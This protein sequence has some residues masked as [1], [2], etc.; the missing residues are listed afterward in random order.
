MQAHSYIPVFAI[1]TAFLLPVISTDALSADPKQPGRHSASTI[2]SKTTYRAFLINNVFAYFANNGDG[3]YNPFSG[4]HEG[5]EFYKGQ[6]KHIFYEEGL[7]WGGYHG[8]RVIPKVGGS[9]YRHAL[10]PG[11]IVTGGTAGTTPIAA[12]DTTGD[13]YRIYRVRPDIG[14]GVSYASVQATL[15]NEE[16]SFLS[17]YQTLTSEEVFNQYI[18]DRNEWPA[19]LGAPFTY[20]KN[21]QGIQRTSGPYDPNFDTP[22]I[23]G[24]MQTLWYVANDL[25]SSRTY[26]LAGCPPIGLE[27][28]RTIWGY[29]RNTGALTSSIF[30]RTV[31]VNKSGS[32]VDSMYFAEFSDPD[33]GNAGDDFVGCDTT[34][35][36]GYVYNSWSPDPTFGTN[37]P[38]GGIVLLQGPCVPSVGDVA[39]FDFSRR[40][41]HKNLPMTAFFGFTHSSSFWDS[42]PLLGADGD[43]QWYNIMQGLTRS[44]VPMIDPNT[45]RVAQ[46]FSPGDPVTSGIGWIDGTYGLTPSDR[47]MAM[48]SGSFTL[49]NGDTQEIVIA[50]VAGL[51]ADRLSSVSMLRDYATKLIEFWNDLTGIGT[52]AGLIRDDNTNAQSYALFQNYP[53]PF[54]PTTVLS[55]QL[56]VASHV[57]LAVY[58]LLGREVAV[59]IDEDKG[60]GSYE[61]AFDARGL[62]GGMYIYRLT[63]GSFVQSMKMVLM[64]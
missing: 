10:Q 47:Q 21:T 54:N 41:A 62:A 5:F 25:D 43:R 30:E 32:A 15:Q 14:P 8:G 53:N 59:L 45:G 4:N 23:P 64:K 40:I 61:V 3:L 6:A 9:S 63:A 7:L 13:R 49:A 31:L 20:G 50:C 35:N 34:L 11:P 18:K 12:S 48:S 52:T 28:Q 2:E 17:R 16:T 36:L 19:D 1:A 37:I 24:A 27:V 29:R 22:G 57:R 51:G 39:A 56:P 55:F 33:L 46:F 44:G 58:D 26:S 60:A 42:P 38:A